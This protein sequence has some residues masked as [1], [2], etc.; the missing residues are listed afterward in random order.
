MEQELEAL[1]DEARRASG[2]AGS[3]TVK[4]WEPYRF[5]PRAS[6][7]F[8]SSSSSR[9]VSSTVRGLTPSTSIEGEG[10]LD[11]SPQHVNKDTTQGIPG[12]QGAESSHSNHD[13]PINAFGTDDI[14]A[15][16]QLGA[17]LLLSRLDE[18]GESRACVGIAS[19]PVSVIS[20]NSSFGGHKD[21]ID[22]K[23]GL[24]CG[25]VESIGCLKDSGSW[26]NFIPER[27]A[28]DLECFNRLTP[29]DLREPI[30]SLSLH[31]CTPLGMIDIVFTCPSLP[32][33]GPHKA[34]FYVVADPYLCYDGIL[35][36][37]VCERI[38]AI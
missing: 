4:P 15:V 9:S 11:Q 10:K 24:E 36:Q 21:K 34:T 7:S 13:R 1:S 29:S 2:A 30:S 33:I 23:I 35:G 17:A 37:K 31:G 18:Q 8:D 25:R 3:H 27:T 12:P 20:T 6:R 19:G 5:D 28:R 38:G 32:N 14:E 26:A 16:V 22:I